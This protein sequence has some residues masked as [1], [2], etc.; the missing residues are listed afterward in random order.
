MH[1][2]FERVP[3]LRPI[4]LYGP[5]GQHIS[6]IVYNSQFV[7]P[8]SVF[9]A[10]NGENTDGHKYIEQAL[11]AGASAIIGTNE[12]SMLPFIESF[13][14]ASFVLVE[15]SREAL[16]HLADYFYHH[17]QD[18]LLKIAVT[19]TNG[20]TTVATY[21]QRLFNLLSIPCGM[22]GT[23]GIWKANEKMKF[24][25]STPTTPMSSDIHFIFNELHKTN[26]EAAVMEVSSI[27]LDQKRVEGIFFDIAIHTN[28]SEEHLEYHK[29][30]EHYKKSKLLLFKQTASS[31]VNLDDIMAPEIL[32][33]T[34]KNIITYSHHLS[35]GADL[36]WTNCRHEEKGIMFDLYFK[37]EKHSIRLP[38]Y[39]EYN[40]GNITAA[41]G[42]AL[43]IGVDLKE[44]LAVLPEMK[45]AEGR[46][47]VIHGPENRKAVI[48]YAHTPVALEKILTEVRKLPHNRLIAMIAGIGIRDFGKM[49]KMAKAAEGKAD[50]IIVTVDHPG[51][52][53]PEK[54]IQEVLS[55][56]SNPA[57]P[58]ITAKTRKE[59]V[60]KALEE[61]GPNDI[62][63]LTSGCINGCQIVKGQSIPH[64][65]EE[66]IWEFFNSF[67]L[68]NTF[69]AIQASNG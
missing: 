2:Y 34:Q 48:D 54:I 14:E 12:K 44:I 62:I 30:F 55:G 49:P 17:A 69:K 4:Q 9:F 38:L 52:N 61:S 16:A 50:F 40:A 22:L 6:S 8:Q 58:V 56:F 24:E 45:Q 59:G 35:S 29:T 27:A 57:E 11:Q 67:P 53:N 60:K 13:P 25:K 65:D 68:A 43:S 5:C 26:H 3:N 39:G 15:D 23:N 51:F 21:V 1:I 32:L 63:L 37:K 7:Q 10:I 47:Q 41:I 36:V 66:I 31:V 46:F 19:G 33:I 20:K 28:L 42:A 64:S 18:N